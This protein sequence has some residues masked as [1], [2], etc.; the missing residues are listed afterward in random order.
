MGEVFKTKEEYCG[1]LNYLMKKRD[2]VIDHIKRFGGLSLG[3]VDQG[4]YAETI[5][6][7]IRNYEDVDTA[8]VKIAMERYLFRGKRE[9]RKEFKDISY[10]EDLEEYLLSLGI[11]GDRAKK[12][13]KHISL[14]QYSEYCKHHIKSETLQSYGNIHEFACAIGSLGSWDYIASY[15]PTEVQS[16]KN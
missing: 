5:Q 16:F 15:F 2:P 6:N 11:E 14:G 1:F 9:Q 12:L 8:Y 4:E 10:S 7:R 3:M 13:T